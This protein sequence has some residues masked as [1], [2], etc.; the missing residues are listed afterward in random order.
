M[1]MYYHIIAG[2][3][4]GNLIWR[5]GDLYYNCKIEIHQLAYMRIAIPY[6]AAK[7]KF[8]NI[9]A[10]AIL[11]SIAKF[12]CNSGQ[13]FRLYG[14]NIHTGRLIYLAVSLIWHACRLG[15]MQVG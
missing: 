1:Y 3:L 13:Y 12:T 14:I 9:L 10:I 15:P 2:K 8:A 4:V 6:Q 11:G 7:F 5:F